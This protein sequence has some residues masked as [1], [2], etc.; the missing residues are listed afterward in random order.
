MTSR[1]SIMAEGTHLLRT[2][3]RSY[4]GVPTLPDSDWLND[5][6]IDASFV[7]KL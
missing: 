7:I 3:R 4:H 5:R 6:Q 1:V 2:M